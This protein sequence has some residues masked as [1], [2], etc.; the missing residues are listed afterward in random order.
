MPLRPRALSQPGRASSFLGFKAAEVR[1]RALSTRSKSML[2]DELSCPVCCEIF[3]DPVVLKCSHSFCKSC[4]QQ[5]WNKKASKRECPVCRTK[6]SLQE[7]TVSLALKNV[8]DTLLKEQGIKGS[9]GGAEGAGA[10]GGAGVGG[11]IRTEELCPIHGEPVKLYCQEDAE[12]LCCV[13]Q[14]SKKHQ[15]HSVC[16]VEEAAQDLKVRWRESTY[17]LWEWMTLGDGR[18]N[19]CERDSQGVTDHF[20]LPN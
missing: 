3:T 1:P 7:P 14:T 6:C 11:L 12:V 10:S 13:C 20:V 9:G 8:C 2:E 18:S 17:Y 4:L 15:G 5:F 16:P 19:E